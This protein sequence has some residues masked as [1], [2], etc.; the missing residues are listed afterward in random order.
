MEGGR[1]DQGRN[2]GG[3]KGKNGSYAAAGSFTLAFVVEAF[4]V[5]HE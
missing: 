5:D 3:R 1:K 4:I 2:K